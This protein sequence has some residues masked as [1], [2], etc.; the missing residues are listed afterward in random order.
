LRATPRANTIR[1]PCA[2]PMRSETSSCRK[3]AG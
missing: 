3:I 1:H 2:P